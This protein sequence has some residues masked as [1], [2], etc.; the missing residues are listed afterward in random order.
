VGASS[1]GAD[2][3][4]TPGNFEEITMV[5]TRR[6]LVI[7]DSPETRRSVRSVLARFSEFAVPGECE[8]TEEA[9]ASFERCR[10]ELVILDLALPLK[11]GQSEGGD[12]AGF[13][14]AD[15]L[16]ENC[17]DLR[18]VVP[19]FL[20]FSQNRQRS[21]RSYAEEKGYSLVVKGRDESMEHLADAIASYLSGRTVVPDDDDALDLAEVL[22]E[23][24]LPDRDVTIVRLVAAGRTDREISNLITY[25]A[26]NVED[27]RSKLGKELVDR[28]F[29]DAKRPPKLPP[30]TTDPRD[31]KSALVWFLYSYVAIKPA[32]HQR[33]QR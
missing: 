19:H 29:D 24:G 21:A 27:R 9:W 33:G 3:A 25:A 8:T 20:I 4:S 30:P 10:P 11:V 13:E 16:V 32:P 6:V 7:E 14:L 28:L 2:G 23:L 1:S 17:I 12:L 5:G 15:E 22:A 31:F 18:Y 26:G